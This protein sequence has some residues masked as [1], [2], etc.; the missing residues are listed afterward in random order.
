MYRIALVLL[1]VA[2]MAVAAPGAWGANRATFTD[3]S[4]DACCTEDIQKVVVSNN[5]AG[6]IT[7][8]VTAPLLPDSYGSA[9]HRFIEITT[10]RS[11]FTIGS[12]PNTGEGY[13]LWRNEVLRG[14]V[15]AEERGDVFR[16][17]ID[18]H[19][20]GDA[21]QF[22]FSVAFWSA[23]SMHAEADGA[24]PWP[25]RVRLALGRV[26]PVLSV[27]QSG[28]AGSRLT[29]GLALH[30]GRELLA[31]G[32][33]RCAATVGGRRLQLLVK[34]FIAHR[35]ICVWKVPRWTRGKVVRGLIGVR[36]TDQSS[37]LKQR[38]FQRL[39]A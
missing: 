26:R 21:D 20:L 31:S 30:V 25:Y 5:D 27:R 23:G 32:T 15:R 10:E 4:G 12:D 33:I 14:R 11:S 18:R 6:M 13:V 16:F 37:S 39:L 19:R 29:V 35:A 7:F 28:N 24:G 17:F 8:A 34:D 9:S 22:K 3:E 2:C 1:A 38:S 36:V